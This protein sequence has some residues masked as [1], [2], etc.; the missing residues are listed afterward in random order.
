MEVAEVQK[1]VLVRTLKT[2]T[3][4]NV[5]YAVFDFDGNKHGSLEVVT[6]KEIKRTKFDTPRGELTKYVRQHMSG[7]D[8]GD[9]VLVPTTDKFPFVR[10]VRATHALA[11]DMWGHNCVTV[12]K[13]VEKNVVEVLKID[14]T[15]GNT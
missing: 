13:N 11:A 14:H 15:K 8:I 1:Q 7:M 12:H 6:G 4:L 2:L 10:V 5:P 3:A 9:V